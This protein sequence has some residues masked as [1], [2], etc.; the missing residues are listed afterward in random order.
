MPKR[1]AFAEYDF[2]WF[3]R[4]YEAVGNISNQEMQE[5]WAKILA[6]EISKPASFSLST[7]D[8]LKNM[9]Q[10]DAILFE[11]ICNFA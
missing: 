9:G 10:K 5:K 1:D 8:A 7:I 11:K 4:F 3:I 2:D 6:G